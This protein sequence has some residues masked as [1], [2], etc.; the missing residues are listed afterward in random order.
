ME[1]AR[2]KWRE[3]PTF[4]QPGSALTDYQK[5]LFSVTC[6]TVLLDELRRQATER[7]ILKELARGLCRS[8][9]QIDPA[10]VVDVGDLV[11]FL[12]DKLE[13]S[14]REILRLHYAEGLTFADIAQRLG[15]SEVAIR[16]AHQRILV[17]L[18]L[19]VMDS[20]SLDVPA[21]EREI[22]QM[23]YRQGLPFNR[24]AEVLGISEDAVKKAHDDAWATLWNIQGLD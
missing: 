19:I 20:L 12:L 13:P 8:Y 14:E 24:I 1:R 21:Y 2:E 3:Y 7:K 15:R 23:R 4:P 17:E 22:L 11:E 10:K 18:R 16:K 5:K 6:R 9:S